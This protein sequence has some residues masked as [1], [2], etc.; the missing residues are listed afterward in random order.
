MHFSTHGALGHWEICV[1]ELSSSVV[2]A[3]DVAYPALIVRC[4]S[5]LDKSCPLAVMAKAE[6]TTE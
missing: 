4:T 5:L 6:F 3:G 1:F 2:L